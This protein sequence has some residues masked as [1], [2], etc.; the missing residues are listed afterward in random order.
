MTSNIHAVGNSTTGD[1]IGQAGSA[2]INPRW[3]QH[4]A[5]DADRSISYQTGVII[6]Y[7]KRRFL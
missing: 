4:L 6:Y 3:L 7:L 1:Q 2:L 5:K